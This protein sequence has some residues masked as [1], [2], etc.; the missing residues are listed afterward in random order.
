[1]RGLNVC[2]ACKRALTNLKR[3]SPSQSWLFIM[4]KQI[5]KWIPDTKWGERIWVTNWHIHNLLSTGSV[6]FYLKQKWLWYVRNADVYLCI[7]ATGPSHS[8][9]NNCAA[10][11]AFGLFQNKSDLPI[12]PH[13]NVLCTKEDT[14]KSSCSIIWMLGNGCSTL[15]YSWRLR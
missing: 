2:S 1:M 11:R 3:G 13:F 10:E 6:K 9:P 7:I 14:W 15:F 12:T 8:P 5:I 4:Q